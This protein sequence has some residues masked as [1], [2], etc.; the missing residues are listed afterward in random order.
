M[1]FADRANRSLAWIRPT[2]PP[3]GLN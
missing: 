2:I 3:I 1:R